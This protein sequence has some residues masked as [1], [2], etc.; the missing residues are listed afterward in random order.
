MPNRLNRDQICSFSEP[1]DTNDGYKFCVLVVAAP[2][3]EKT[4]WQAKASE[5]DLAVVADGP[6]NSSSPG[7]PSQIPFNVGQSRFVPVVEAAV[8]EE[9]KAIIRGQVVT[10][11]FNSS[12]EGY[13]GNHIVSVL[14]DHEHFQ[15]DAQ[16]K[17]ETRFPARIRAAATALKNVG[18]LGDFQL[19][20][21]AGQLT[22][23][24]LLDWDF[25]QREFHAEQTYLARKNGKIVCCTLQPDDNVGAPG[26]I[27][28]GEKPRNMEVGELLCGQTEP[29]PVFLKR[30]VNRWE[31]QGEFCYHSDT[32]DPIE[33]TRASGLVNRRVTHIIYLKPANAAAVQM[34]AAELDSSLDVVSVV[35]GGRKLVVHLRRERDRSIVELKKRK[36]L[37]ETGALICECCGFDFADFYGERG[38]EFCEAHHRVPLGTLDEEAETS[39]EDLAIVCSNCHRMLHRGPDFPSVEEL[40]ILVEERATRQKERSDNRDTVSSH[41]IAL[42]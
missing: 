21:R 11:D 34:T 35:E 18:L 8:R 2:L 17:D 10:V 29:F 7:M 16:L 24:K 40:R 5:T 13:E 25:L 37:A 33:L 31:Y 32:K 41:Q 20:H 19:V 23:Q 15:I 28:V 6:I 30:G 9:H 22:I 36:V 42:S 38:T 14:E 27:M 1:T 26:V 3:P 4:A 39:L 12:S